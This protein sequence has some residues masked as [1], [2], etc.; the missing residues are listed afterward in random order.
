MAFEKRI[1]NY[2]QLD[3]NMDYTVS[4]SYANEFS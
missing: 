1:L 4:V 3:I 2:M